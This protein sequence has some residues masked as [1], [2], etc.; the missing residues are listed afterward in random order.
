MTMALPNTHISSLMCD[1]LGSIPATGVVG[2]RLPL[3][4]ILFRQSFT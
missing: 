2:E 1:R 3:Y 4:D